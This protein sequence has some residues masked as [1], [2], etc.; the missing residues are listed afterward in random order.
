MKSPRCTFIHS[1][2]YYCDIG[3]HVF[4]MEKFGR[5]NDALHQD[6]D[7]PPECF[8]EPEAATVE[9]VRLV[10][11]EAYVN[12]LLGLK[13][14][15]RTFPSEL[16]I[17][18]DIVRAYFMAA[19]GTLLAGRRALQD[20]LSMN[21]TGGFHHAFPDHAEGFCYVNDVAVAIR[22]LKSE[23]LI[24]RA[25]V[26]DCD[27]HQGNGTAFIFRMEPL[28]F[29][30]SM[31]QENNYP[32]KQ[33]SDLDIGLRDGA[34]DDEYLGLLE[35][36]LPRILDEHRPKLVT[37]V[38][39]ADPYREDVLGGLGLTLDGLRRRDECVIRHCLERRIPLVA[40]LAGGYAIKAEDTIRI[41]H[42]TGRLLWQ[43][44][45]G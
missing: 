19:G 25:A 13:H 40:V 6:G 4:P 7:I 38:A 31:H 5:V 16:P 45:A 43:A 24:D 22:K 8:L 35:E 17:G 11:T 29:T 39:G 28:V 12:D 9:D 1:P 30:F 20:G 21:L 44:G 37:Y 14:T 15:P 27:L 2:K 3:E 42:T 23:G 33:R 34:T 10:H 32:V 26:V 18:E 41:H 36:H